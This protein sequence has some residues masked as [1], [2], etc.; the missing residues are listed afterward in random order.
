MAAQLRPES[1]LSERVYSASLDDRVEM[2]FHDADSDMRVFVGGT[3]TDVLDEHELE[4][5]FDDEEEPQLR[6][7]LNDVRRPPQPTRRSALTAL[8]AQY[9]RR[10]RQRTTAPFGNMVVI[11]ENVAGMA[12]HWR[13]RLT[14]LMEG[15]PAA[16]LD[17]A[18]DGAPSSRCRLWWS[19]AGTAVSAA[20]LTPELRAAFHR[21]LDLNPALPGGR[22][23][24]RWATVTTKYASQSDLDKWNAARERFSDDDLQKMKQL[25]V[26]YEN[27]TL[28]NLASRERLLCLGFPPNH[29]DDSSLSEEKR[30]AAVGQSF[31]LLSAARVL[32]ANLPHLACFGSPPVINACSAFSGIGGAELVLA[33]LHRLGLL[34]LRYIISIELDPELRA[35][36]RRWFEKQPHLNDVELLE[37]GDIS[38]VSNARFADIVRCV[39]GIQLFIGGS[40]CNGFAGNNRHMHHNGGKVGT[41][42]WPSSHVFD[43]RRLIDVARLVNAELGV[44]LL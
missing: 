43:Y 36:V 44:A 41:E 35:I 38:K 33:E 1:L 29:F 13:Q 8:R 24:A 31:A 27:G 21:V 16:H 15:L 37:V 9:F 14:D 26:V 28:R 12:L 3:V 6:N 32:L 22:K 10:E 23:R 34:R 4:V 20:E 39:G 25:N 18:D 5:V 30:M 40:P 42:N 19:K 17:A 11:L 2:L 7:L